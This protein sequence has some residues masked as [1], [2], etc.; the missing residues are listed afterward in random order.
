MR[1]LALALAIPLAAC[2]AATNAPSL[3]PRA[4]EAID[5]RVPVPETPVST[6]P[7]A[8][9]VNQ[10]TALVSQAIAG[11]AAFA[12]LA[13]RA[14][15][16]AAQAGEKESESWVVAQQ[17]LSAAIAAREPVAAAI[18]DIDALGAQRIQTLG[19]IGA[20]DLKAIDAAAARLAEIDGREAATVA[21]IQAQLAR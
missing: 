18:G 15:D 1:R 7:S 14:E 20:A 3:A 12:P 4:A 13:G 9:V 16:L 10:L 6:T 2:S 11:D 19:G 17:A 5:P 21:R 8:S